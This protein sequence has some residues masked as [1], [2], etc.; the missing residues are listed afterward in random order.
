MAC[1]SILRLAAALENGPPARAIDCPK[2]CELRT[3]IGGAGFTLFRR[4]RAFTLNVR[5]YRRLVAGPPP[6]NPPPPGP[7]PRPPPPPPPPRG[8]PPPPPGGPPL[9]C[10][11]LLLPISGPKPKVFASRRFSV[12]RDGPVR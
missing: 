10:A 11:P 4:F 9:G 2:F 5:L 8:P 3:P 6:P 7:R 1:S 12:N